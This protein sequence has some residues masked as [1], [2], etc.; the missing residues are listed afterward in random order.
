MYMQL[1]ESDMHSVYDVAD[2]ETKRAAAL[3]L[4]SKMHHKKTAG[5]TSIL[6]AIQTTKNPADIDFKI[7]SLMFVGLKMKV[8]K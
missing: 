7:T 2:L 8:V 5:Y 1:T 4:M 6:R 3:K